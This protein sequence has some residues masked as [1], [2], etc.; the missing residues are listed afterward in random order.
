MKSCLAQAVRCQLSNME[1]QTQS[2]DSPSEI[3]RDKVTLG[4]T[5]K[6]NNFLILASYHF[7]D[8]LY[9]SVTAFS[10]M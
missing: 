5:S 1:I 8:H 10:E 6:M 7:T 9:S 3:L 4:Q 2:Q